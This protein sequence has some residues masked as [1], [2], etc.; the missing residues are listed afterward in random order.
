VS[1]PIATTTVSVLRAD[2]D[3]VDPYDPAPTPATVASGVR[4]VISSPAGT[5]QVAGGQQ[6]IVNFRLDCDTTDLRH[7]DQIVDD[8]SGE[9]FDVVWVHDRTGLGLDYTQAGLRQ[10]EGPFEETGS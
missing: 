3:N 5:E 6:E 7:R 4:A 2:L 10:V 8:A 9:R 1:I